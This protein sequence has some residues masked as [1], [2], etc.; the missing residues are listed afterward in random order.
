M[1]VNAF[2][3]R[4]IIYSFQSF[5]NVPAAQSLI[6]NLLLLPTPCLLLAFLLS[7]SRSGSSQSG[8]ALEGDSRSSSRGSLEELSQLR[9]RETSL[10][11]GSSGG[12]K[13]KI[14]L[15]YNVY[16]AKYVNQPGAQSPDVADSPE[17]SPESSPKAVKKVKLYTL[18]SC[19]SREI[20]WKL[21]LLKKNCTIN[22]FAIC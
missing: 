11:C 22:S 7:H 16:M 21:A 1:W 17:N 8:G 4:A 5:K 20:S 2:I 10:S 13:Q 19:V 9:H 18:Y 6:Q 3:L 12:I 15:D 14:L